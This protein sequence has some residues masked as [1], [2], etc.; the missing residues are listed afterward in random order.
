MVGI[1]VGVDAFLRGA[2][3]FFRGFRMAA[4]LTSGA[5][6]CRKSIPRDRPVGSFDGCV[7]FLTHGSYGSSCNMS[8]AVAAADIS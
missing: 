6:G 3:F 4:A 7:G 1:G 5:H 8:E 2:A